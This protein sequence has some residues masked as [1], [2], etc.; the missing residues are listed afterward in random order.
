MEMVLKIHIRARVNVGS[1]N[2]G[3]PALYTTNG[4]KGCF[5][6]KDPLNARPNSGV[7]R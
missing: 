4:G 7:V 5:F 1:K 3:L 2:P 6:V